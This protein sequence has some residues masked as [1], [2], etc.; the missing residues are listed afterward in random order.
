MIADRMTG[1]TCRSSSMLQHMAH[2]GPCRTEGGESALTGI[3]GNMTS[4]RAVSHY[5]KRSEWPA[6]QCGLCRSGYTQALEHEDW[7]GWWGRETVNQISRE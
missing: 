2:T 1:R 3:K 4:F 7:G 5:S 6:C